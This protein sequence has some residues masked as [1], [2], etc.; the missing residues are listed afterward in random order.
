[1]AKKVLLFGDIGIDDTIAILYAYMNDEI[2]IV[3]MVADYGNI[4]RENALANIQY[5]RSLFDS[6]EIEN[7]KIIVGAEIPM[8]GELPEYVP[9]IHGEY[10]LGPII[11]ETDG[12]DGVSENFHDIVEIIEQYQDELVIVNIGRLTSLATMF[13][14]YPDLMRKVKSY[15][16][17]GGAFWVPGN[18]TAVSEAN[19]HGDPV[20]AQLVL[21]NTNN[22]VTI[23]PLNVTQQAIATPEMVDYID[24]VGELPIVKTL[25]DYYYDYYK[26]RDPNI[27]GSPLHDVLTLMAIN[28]EDMFTFQNLPVQIVQ[29]REGTERGQSI[30]DIRPYSNMEEEADEEVRTHRIAFGLDYPKFYT[31]FMTVMSG[32]RFD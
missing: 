22:N 5:V 32:Q 2:D 26:E 31:R 10:G 3:G 19:F 20:A 27:Q 4:S 7:V 13:L 6:E 18:V 15:Y 14:L 12:Q 25:L 1:M 24:Q 8:T 9:E 28:Q 23:I 21:A 11:P 17:M 16:I 30:A 29:A